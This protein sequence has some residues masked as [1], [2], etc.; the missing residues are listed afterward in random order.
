M[1]RVG[2]PLKIMVMGYFIGMV[3]LPKIA[4]SHLRVCDALPSDC[5]MCSLICTSIENSFP[6]R[7]QRE[8]PS[9]ERRQS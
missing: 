9:T 1:Q 7:S 5:L 8:E 2:A 6:S 4:Q 3:R